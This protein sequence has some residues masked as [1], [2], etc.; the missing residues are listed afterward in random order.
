ML[1]L[2]VVLSVLAALSNATSAVLQR[3]ASGKVSAKHLFKGSF[4]LEVAQ[5]KL[6]LAG[7]GL[8]VAAFILQAGALHSGSLIVVEPLMTV[9]LLF[10]LVILHFKLGVEA[11]RREWLGVLALCAGLSGLLVVA[12]PRNGQLS[13]D[14]GNWTI[15]S[16]II[17][18]ILLAGAIVTRQQASPRLRAG[19]AGVAAGASFALTSAF[20]KLAVA[21]LNH[22]FIRFV[23]T[24]EVYAL[25]ASGAASILMMQSAYSAGP[26]ATSQ[27][28]IEITDPAV[29]TAIGIMLF[30]DTVNHSVGALVI[31]A[32]CAVLLTVGVVAVGGSPKIHRAAKEGI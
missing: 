9:D 23:T 5:N 28:A 10:L 18:A 32:A 12:D 21:Q 15:T 11:G 3:R 22:G 19:V 2:V 26:L 30:G 25:M 16:A 1:A 7:M 24:W 20:T 4:V 14:V 17:V 29:S 27:P 13:F 6:W 31:E 8:Q